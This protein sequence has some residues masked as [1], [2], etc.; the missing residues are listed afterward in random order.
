MLAV[1]ERIILF[2]NISLSC[3]NGSS[4]MVSIRI[5]FSAIRSKRKNYT[6]GLFK[7]IREHH[8]S[9]TFSPNV[10]FCVLDSNLNDLMST[11]ST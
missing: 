6:R 11:V 5:E 4:E 2:L 3:K 9:H 10:N 7:Q 8:R 1:S